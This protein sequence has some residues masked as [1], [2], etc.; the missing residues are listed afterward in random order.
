VM[1]THDLDTLV[2][3]SDRVAVIAD[4]HIV[5]LDNL[6]NVVSNSHP[7]ITNFFGGDRGKRALAG[8]GND[9]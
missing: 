9:F 7:F 3:L 1:T 6:C 2:A 8:T 4:Q 5:A